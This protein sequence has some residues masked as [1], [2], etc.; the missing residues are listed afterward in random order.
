MGALSERVVRGETEE[1]HQG[2]QKNHEAEPYR[3]VLPAIFRIS[4]SHWAQP[5]VRGLQGIENHSRK[6]AHDFPLICLIVPHLTHSGCCAQGKHRGS[7]CR[8]AQVRR[9]LR[10]AVAEQPDTAVLRALLLH[11][12]QIPKWP[13]REP[14]GITTPEIGSGARKRANDQSRRHYVEGVR[15]SRYCRPLRG[16]RPPISGRFA[17]TFRR[18]LA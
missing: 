15:V 14:D 16:S 10:P 2:D 12:G 8:S 18:E 13:S 17:H 9:R 4:G 11:S 1:A 6:L 5:T 3:I 7:L